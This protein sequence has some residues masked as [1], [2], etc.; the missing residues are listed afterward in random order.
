MYRGLQI[1]GL[2]VLMGLCASCASQMSE[3]PVQ[4]GSGSVSIQPAKLVRV[5][6]FSRGV[7]VFQYQGMV[8]GTQTQTLSFRSGQINDVLKSLVF[9]DTGGGNAGEVTFPAA[10]P[11]SVTLRGFL[12]NLNNNPSRRDILRQL[13]GVSVTLWLKKPVGDKITGRIIDLLHSG[14]YVPPIESTAPVV[15]YHSGP[16]IARNSGWYIN[17]LSHAQIKR[18]GM[19]NV[20]SIRINDRRLRNSFDQALQAMANQTNTHKR[21]MTLW[22]Q[23][24]GERLVRFAYLLETPLWRM[25]YR[26][27]LPPPADAAATNPASRR[28]VIQGL[29]IVANQTD[30]DWNNVQLDIRGGEPLSFIEDLY[31]PLYMRRPVA[32]GPNGAYLTPQT[33]GQGMPQPYLTQ[34]LRKNSYL[35]QQQIGGAMQARSFAGAVGGG[36][37]YQ[38]KSLA[39][40]AQQQLTAIPF[41]PLQ[42][43][44]AMASAGVVHPAFDYHVKD[45][46]VPRGQSAMVPVLVT[47]IRAT[48]LDFFT[49]GQPSE[50]PFFAVRI[51]ND[52]T[53]YLPPGTLTAYT[54]SIYDGEF[55][56]DALPPGQHHVYAFAVDQSATVRFFKSTQKSILTAASLRRGTLLLHNQVTMNERYKIHNTAAHSRMML[57]RSAIGKDWKILAPVAGVKL[58]HG[59]YQFAFTVQPSAKTTLQIR[60]R[61]EQTQAS[62]LLNQNIVMLREDLKIKNLPVPIVHAI[63][64][65][66]KLAAAAERR[67]EALNNTNSR[68]ADARADEARLRENLQAMKKVSKAYEQV[69]AELVALDH[70][71]TEAMK[72]SRKDQ[73]KRNDAIN[74]VIQYWATTVIPQTAVK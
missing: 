24:R 74:A 69:A 28:P 14:F 62:D 4:S 26:L 3:Q 16:A 40:N 36:V 12:V 53:R 45:V 47:P 2:I 48:Q 63:R 52:T 37:A 1:I 21:P 43:V 22:F 73:L 57:V 30:M 49:L 13:H 39:Y 29:A 32:S 17:L 20:Q 25:T 8:H 68:I 31:Q 33:Y 67:Q 54:G 51:T 60:R 46:T 10:T 71:L 59:V 19:A 11:L 41:N 64:H 61:Q 65:A 15:R 35:P 9:Q 6:L 58:H 70:Y 34:N 5:D 55:K 56:M 42:G 50:H 44:N 27:I 18:V 72:Q 23:G 66:I 7:G 38:Q